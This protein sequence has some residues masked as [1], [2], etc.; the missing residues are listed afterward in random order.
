MKIIK[1]AGWEEQEK[2]RKY[3]K[4]LHE[5]DRIIDM[6]RTDP[7]MAI[8]EMINLDI[9]TQYNVLPWD[10][11]D[12]QRMKNISSDGLV[13]LFSKGRDSLIRE[14]NE[15]KEF[16]EEEKRVNINEPYQTVSLTQGV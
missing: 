8:T 12:F 5:I 7:K 6:A 10:V 1:T 4:I 9:R 3:K 16:G 15:I 14:M 13:S 11:T 2:I